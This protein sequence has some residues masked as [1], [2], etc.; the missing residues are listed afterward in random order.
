MRSPDLARTA[1]SLDTPRR[2]RGDRR[3]VRI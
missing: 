2:E 3:Q 1:A